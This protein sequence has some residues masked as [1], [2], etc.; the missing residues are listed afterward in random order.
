MRSSLPKEVSPA[1]PGRASAADEPDHNY[2]EKYLKSHSSAEAL[3]Y[4]LS[5]WRMGLVNHL[6]DR[7]SYLDVGCGTGGYFQLLHGANRIVGIDQ[8]SLMIKAANQLATSSGYRDKA[9][10]FCGT[11]EG[12]QDNKKFDVIRLGVYG[13]YLPLSKSTIEKAMGLL[14]PRGVIFLNFS[15][16]S[17]IIALTLNRKIVMTPSRLS[18][19]LRKNSDL[20]IIAKWIG[21]GSF[22]AIVGKTP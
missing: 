1:T 19:F 10:F 9:V 15:Y 2:V 8:S 7:Y 14:T 6:F 21:R 16:T 22:T 13:S 5:Y 4:R 3:D 18:S 11:F 20:Q 17:K 12:Y